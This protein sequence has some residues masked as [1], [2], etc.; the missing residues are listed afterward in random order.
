MRGTCGR[1]RLFRTLA[2]AAAMLAAVQARAETVEDA[3]PSAE[4]LGALSLEELSE[5]R[6]TSVSKRPEPLGQAAASIYLITN[7]QILR[8]GAMSLPEAL[9][10]A[11]N[12]SVM[13]I[14]ALD[15]SITARGFA[16]FESANKLL[17]M[18]DGRS[19]YTP[20]FSG[21]D[22]DQHHVL[23]E[24]I[25]RIEVVS[26]PGGVLWGA[27]AVNG[28]VSVATK[29]ALDTVGVLAAANAGTLDRDVRARIGW[30]LGTAGAVRIYG[31]AFKRGD[32]ETAAGEAANDGW[33]GL[34]GGFRADFAW[35]GDA[36]TLQGDLQDA[37]I[38][39]SLGVPGY[40]RGGNLLG[41]WTR[42]WSEQLS[43][44]VQAYYDDIRREA[45]LVHDEQRTWDIEAQA[46][47]S[48]GRH[49]LVLGGGYRLM[50]DEFR[51]LSEPQLLSPPRRKTEIANV[52]V[53]DEIAL[54][55]NL[56]LTLGLKAEE[57]S[58]TEL[59]WLPQ[60]R[61]GWRASD[62]QF[63]WAAVSRALRNPSRIERDFT[64]AGLV[65]PGQ[66]GSEKLV[67]W[68]AGWRGRLTNRASASVSLFYHDYDDLRTNELS[69]P[70]PGGLPIY[71]SN[72][73][74]AEVWG[75]EAWTD[76][77][78]TETWRLSLGG[79]WLGKDL[80][81][82]PGRLDVSNFESGGADPDYWVKLNAHAD[83]TPRLTLDVSLR[84]YGEVPRLNINQ[85]V[86]AD[87][88]AEAGVRLAWR[89]RDDLE[90]YLVG[91]DLLHDR[92]AEASEARRS[93]V[94]RRVSVGFRWTR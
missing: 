36:F 81:I 82:K 74:A 56:L 66:M 72:G 83:L 44:E 27:N 14:D 78:L 94:P 69:P 33:T 90:L 70:P 77:R 59:E 11:P 7:E 60:A 29:S 26:G 3:A 42:R 58:Y 38:D 50:K 63:F 85:Y 15:Y 87:A 30:G 1:R 2:A 64:F 61:L 79:A 35:G 49:N 25:E 23:L 13:R 32:L 71:V 86:G 73:L 39:E 24:D 80:E 65:V 22:W 51:T 41:R 12:L 43:T 54:T 52:F 18:V 28:V 21:V 67:A 17:V 89:A 6:V 16:G 92:H 57:N 84:A 45:R 8:S 53:Q 9:R 62:R 55:S 19:V 31:T 47:W 10:L 46:A 91:Q 88:Y 93:E 37:D 76:L 20:L 5:I 40:V 4:A 75:V 68:E 34:Q 48:L